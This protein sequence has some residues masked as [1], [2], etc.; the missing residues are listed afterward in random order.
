MINQNGRQ[1][2]N[3]KNIQK[4]FVWSTFV[5][6]NH[7]S[8]TFEHDWG[9]NNLQVYPV[10]D[11][12]EVSANH[13]LNTPHCWNFLLGD[14]I[15]ILKCNLFTRII[16]GLIIVIWKECLGYIYLK[17]LISS[18]LMAEWLR[19]VIRNHLEEIP[20]EFESLCCR[21]FCADFWPSLGEQN[22]R[23]AA[24]TEV[25]GARGAMDSASDFE[26]G[27]CG[28]ES[29]RACFWVGCWSSGMILALGARGHGFNSRTAPT[30]FFC[31]FCFGPI[32]A[33]QRALGR[34]LA[35]DSQSRRNLERGH[36]QKL[37]RYRED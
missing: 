9:W 15:T 5:Q 10:R 17:S 4:R 2:L 22:P 29:R 35:R 30:I 31:P 7:Q 1:S 3:W 16:N 25:W 18:A 21:L 12:S 14:S 20:R 26:S 32:S 27:G 11:Q 6:Q 36:P 8:K 23:G 34:N 19:R 33:A 24:R 28:F 13:L 37:E